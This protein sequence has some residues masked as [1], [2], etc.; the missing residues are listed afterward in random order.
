MHYETQ[1]NIIFYGIAA[2]A[3][4]VL[5]LGVVGTIHVWGLGKA[6]HLDAEIRISKWITSIL[7]ASLF[8]TQ[9]LEYGVLA[10]LSHL[11]IF[12][13]FIS[14]FLL[15]SFHFVLNWIVPSSS[16]F[17]DFFKSG[18]GNMALA[19]WGDLGGLILLVGIL[20]AIF[21]RYMLRPEKLNTI[22]DDSIAIWFLFIITVTGFMC[23]AVRLAVRP[24]AKDAVYSFAVNWI[25]PT[26]RQFKWSEGH[27]SLF[28]WIHSSISFIF[29]AYI[30]FSKF[31]HILASPLAYAFVTASNRYT[32]EN[33]LKRR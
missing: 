25:V 6:K 3:T 30:P 9:I 22:S 5:L 17:Y 31:K 11:M 15:T 18:N 1:A 27:I 29:I 7:K 28:F 10:W 14:L 24:E 19:F 21:R 33:W 16:A 20:M 12:W 26:L 23:E 2:L 32:K 13:G 4:F 8:E